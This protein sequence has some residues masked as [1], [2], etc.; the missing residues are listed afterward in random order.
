MI[1]DKTVADAIYETEN[2]K[3]L[4][5]WKDCNQTPKYLIKHLAASDTLTTVCLIEL[6]RPADFTEANAV[7]E[8]VYEIVG[9]PKCWED[10]KTRY[11]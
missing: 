4:E 3:L 1:K 6:K 11:F 8:T 10:D 7:E 5:V 9:Y 2:P